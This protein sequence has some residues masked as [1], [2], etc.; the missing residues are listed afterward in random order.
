MKRIQEGLIAGLFA[1]LVLA[2][3]YFVDYGPGN[4]LRTLAR[5]FGLDSAG[6]GTYIGFILC[7]LLGGVSGILF[8]ALQRSEQPSLGRSLL[9][10]PGVGLLFWVIVRLLIGTLII[11]VPLDFSSFLFSSVTR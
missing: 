9:L 8:G 5:L 4:A 2:I 10:G 6:A 7:M 1:V 3:L 11:R